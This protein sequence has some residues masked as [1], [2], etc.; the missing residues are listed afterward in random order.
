MEEE[1]PQRARDQ[2]VGDKP[3]VASEVKKKSVLNFVLNA[4]NML[5]E[6]ISYEKVL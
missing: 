1:Q 4:I 2:P 5:Y 6:H 3:E